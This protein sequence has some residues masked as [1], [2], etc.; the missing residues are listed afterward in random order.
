MTG[1][2]RGPAERHS[3]LFCGNCGEPQEGL[4]RVVD[5]GGIPAP[6]HIGDL[7]FDPLACPSVDASTGGI[8]INQTWKRPG[9][10]HQPGEDM[11]R[12][13]SAPGE[14]VAHTLPAC[15]LPYPRRD[16]GQRW[17]TSKYGGRHATMSPNWRR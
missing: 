17:L 6:V 3:P 10:L 12:S 9:Q 16:D 2:V 15:L 7:N 1:L 11:S 5:P 4:P 13:C 8:R 14:G